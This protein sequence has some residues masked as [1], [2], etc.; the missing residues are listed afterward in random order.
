M[1]SYAS[2]HTSAATLVFTC[3]SAFSANAMTQQQTSAPES[4]CHLLSRWISV[5]GGVQLTQKPYALH[6]APV[7]HAAHAAQGRGQHQVKHSAAG[8]VQLTQKPY[9]LH[10]APVCRSSTGSAVQC[11]A[12]QGS[13]VQHKQ[14]VQRTAWGETQCSC[15]RAGAANSDALRAASSACLLEQR[16]ADSA[17]Q[18]K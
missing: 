9:A 8:M 13:A 11:S 14:A 7:E 17:R 12:A 4:V 3:N 1:F 6:P 2:E 15:Y 18:C 10:P 16:R 5:P